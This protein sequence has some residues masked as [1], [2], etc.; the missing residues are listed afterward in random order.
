MVCWV[1]VGL[2]CVFSFPT[3]SHGKTSEY[4]DFARGSLYHDEEALAYEL[5]VLVAE[6]TEYGW[7]FEGEV[8]LE[9]FSLE[10]KVVVLNHVLAAFET[11]NLADDRFVYKPLDQG[12]EVAAPREPMMHSFEEGG[13]GG[14]SS[15][16]LGSF[17][18]QEMQRAG[19]PSPATSAGAAAVGA[20]V[21][22]AFVG[23]VGEGVY[24]GIV[25]YKNDVL[26]RRAV[27]KAVRK[28]I[29]VRND[30]SMSD[31]RKNELIEGYKK[32]AHQ[33]NDAVSSYD[34][35]PSEAI[36]RLDIEYLED[37]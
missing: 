29:K 37:N 36:D 11:E 27:R 23:R 8:E 16:G 22:A 15:T 34:R 6:L 35:Y 31:A 7:D 4:L 28:A 32:E 20:T 2:F 25:E 1:L 24:E 9:A 33:E 13:G 14:G 30:A 19:I 17:A 12:Y 5:D 26:H 18:G 3:S 21:G 10:E